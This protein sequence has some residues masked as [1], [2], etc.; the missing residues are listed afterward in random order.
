MEE[1]SP[2]V[3]ELAAELPVVFEH[4]IRVEEVDAATVASL[5]EE[6]AVLRISVDR[7]LRP[8][9]TAMVVLDLARV[10]ILG[11]AGLRC[12]LGWAD[13]LEVAGHRTIVTN[14]RPIVVKVLAL[15]PGPLL[16]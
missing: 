14:A 11:A 8:G 16:A 9:A 12:L 1:T 6:L 2:S 5:A 7:S 3:A 4:Q 15:A 10:E 13:Q